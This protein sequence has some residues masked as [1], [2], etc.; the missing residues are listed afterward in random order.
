M[1]TICYSYEKARFEDI[2]RHVEDERCRLVD[3][4]ELPV[5]NK[6]FHVFRNTFLVLLAS[7]ALRVGALYS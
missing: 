6:H 4:E 7:L 2:L 3:P 1:V 5:G